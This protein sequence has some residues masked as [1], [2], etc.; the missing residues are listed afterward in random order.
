MRGLQYVKWR[1][2]NIAHDIDLS[3]RTKWHAVWQIG[4]FGTACQRFAL[5][6][7][8][9]SVSFDWNKIPKH[10]FPKYHIQCV[11]IVLNTITGKP[12]YHLLFIF[13]IIQTFQVAKILFL[14]P[15]VKKTHN[16]FEIQFSARTLNWIFLSP[17]K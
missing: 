16:P 14:Y 12:G 7:K 1:N 13:H 10:I 2:K 5:N 4:K 8:C 15:F 6:S 9:S 3:G 17:E 11:S